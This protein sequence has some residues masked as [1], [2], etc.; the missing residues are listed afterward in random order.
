MAGLARKKRVTDSLDDAA[1]ARLVCCDRRLLSSVG[2]GSEHSVNGDRDG[3]SFSLSELVHGFLENHVNGHGDV[4]DDS[5]RV[6]SVDDC[7]DSLEDPL[8]SRSVAALAQNADPYTNK[9]LSH[10]SEAAQE[11][12]FLRDRNVSVFHRSVAAFLREKGHDAA[13][14]KTA[15]DSSAGGV[16]AG[17][18]EFID[19]VQ[20]GPFTW[21]YFVDLDFRAQFEIARPTTRFSEVLGSVPGVFVGGEEELKR[22]VSIVCDAARRCFRSKG[23]SVPPWRKKRFMVNKWLAPCR[24]TANPVKGNPVPVVVTA[25][26]SVGCRLVGFDDVVLGATRCDAVTVRSR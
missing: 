11:F 23:L 6:D 1:R 21:R 15:W 5:E 14:C 25:V 18:H 13:V 12:A 24:R 3:D 20:S 2:S 8:K 19:A 7:A 17:S 26:N 9:L 10:V 22:T 4:D 16:I